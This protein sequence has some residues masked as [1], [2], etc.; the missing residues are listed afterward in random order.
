VDKPI[1]IGIHGVKRAGKNTTADFFQEFAW[2]SDPALSVRQR[3]FADK[4]KWAF[5]RQ[6]FPT[7]SMEE[8]I[9]WV[10]EWK[11]RTDAHFYSP[12]TG[13]RPDSLL[14][15]A[16]PLSD[17]VLFRDALA[18]FCTE[19]ARDIYG[20]DFWVDQLLP[21][22]RNID[23]GSIPV[24][25]RWHEEF[26][27]KQFGINNPATVA[28]VCLITDVRFDNETQRVPVVGG[29]TVK[30]K[31]KDAEDAVLAEAERMGRPVHRSELGLP[32]MLFDFVIDN[33]D[34]DMD[35]AKE[36]TRR[37]WEEINERHR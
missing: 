33:S 37:V 5:A 16:G 28:D 17:P 6:Y 29:Y 32:D 10:D 8:A 11:T 21:V 4:G 7:I 34:N 1:L 36:R 15:V 31:R 13:V 9:K 12:Q 2:S 25:P 22:P 20:D 26:K 14:P 18:Q 35:K 24:R 3:G 30:V 19:G 27:L 23:T